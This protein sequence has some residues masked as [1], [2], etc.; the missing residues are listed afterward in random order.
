VTDIAS[1]EANANAT[2]DRPMWRHLIRLARPHQWAKSVF[3]FIGPVYALQDMEIVPWATV[4]LEVILAA[5]A[6]CLASSGCYVFNDIADIERDRTHPR[7]RRRPIASGA[8]PIPLAKIYG[9]G[10]LLVGLSAAALVPGTGRLWV[11]GLVAAHVMN[12]TA[13]SF[14]LK[15]LVIVD[16]MS[17]AMGFVLRVTAGCIAIGVWP[18]TWLLNVSLFLAMTLAFGKRLGERRT[19]GS[20][21]AATAARGVQQAYSS[22]LLRMALVVSAVGTLLTYSG[23]VLAREAE[24]TTGTHGFNLFW[25]TMIPATYGLLRAITLLETGRFDDPTEL[26]VKD[27]PFQL[28]ALLFAGMTL[29]LMSIDLPGTPPL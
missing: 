7:K 14:M 15:R 23:Y 8:V 21:E 16:V 27:R 5:T 12:V 17:L 10:L 13:Y 3:V 24:Y 22:D 4:L 26:A 28:N 20:A 29:A 18:T 6:F 2:P 11:L 1:P 19:L 9:T 25:L